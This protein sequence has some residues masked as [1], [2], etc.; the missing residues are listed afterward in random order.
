MSWLSIAGPAIHLGALM[1]ASAILLS[2]LF[3][4]QFSHALFLAGYSEGEGAV[5]ILCEGEREVF[6]S[7][8]DGQTYPLALD[9]TGQAQFTPQ[10]TGPYAIQCGSQAKT[11]LVEGRPQPSQ[12]LSSNEGFGL[13]VLVLCGI[14]MAALLAASA[15]LYFHISNNRTEFVKQI[16][17]KAVRLSLRAGERLSNIAISDPVSMGESLPKEFK[18]HSLFSGQ[19]WSHEYEI[20]EPCR[21]LPATLSADAGKD[22]ISLLSQ[23]MI[24]GRA[25]VQIA[26]RWGDASKNGL[27]RLPKSGG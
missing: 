11:I 3:F 22:R 17:G 7:S 14:F 20:E 13:L 27:R 10:S 2:F 25:G 21:A 4:F 12:R 24:D 18:I 5:S 26:K 1:R 23:L 6:I 9:S 16:N 19:S 15:L 8:P